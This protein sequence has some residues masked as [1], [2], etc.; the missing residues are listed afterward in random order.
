MEPW[1][2]IGERHIQN[3]CGG[4]NGRGAVCVR[5]AYVAFGDRRSHMQASALPLLRQDP[6][7]PPGPRTP[8]L[9]QSLQYALRPYATVASTRRFGDR[10]TVTALTGLGKMVVFSDPDAIRDIFAGD[11]D[12]LRAGEATGP[13]LGP[14][15]GWHS[16]LLLDG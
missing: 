13:I 16:L 9:L 1:F 3:R 7:F 10:H 11:G 2:V 14:L 5:R 4:H 6:S 12:T 15:L 8:R